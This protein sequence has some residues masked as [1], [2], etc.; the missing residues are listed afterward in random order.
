MTLDL[1][2]ATAD[3]AAR[4]GMTMQDFVGELISEATGVPYDPQGGLP[5]SA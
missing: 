3:E 1:A 4:R 2:A 5:L